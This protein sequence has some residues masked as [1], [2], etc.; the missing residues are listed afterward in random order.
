MH[1]DNATVTRDDLT[2][3]FSPN[4]GAVRQNC[5]FFASLLCSLLAAAGAVLA[6]QWLQHYERTGQIGSYREQ[7]LRRTAKAWGAET[8][9]LQQV[10]EMLPTLIL[11]SL[12]LFFVAISDYLWSVNWQVAAVVVAFSAAGT[13]LYVVMLVTAT[14]HDQSPFQ[15]APSALLH[16]SWRALL[17]ISQ[18]LYRPATVA[19]RLVIRLLARAFDNA[20]QYTWFDRAEDWLDEHSDLAAR[21]TAAGRGAMSTLSQQCLESLCARSLVYMVSISPD[22]DAVVVACNVSALSD[23][24]S[25]SLLVGSRVLPYLVLHC[26]AALRDLRREHTPRRE[27]RALTVSRA[28]MVLLMADP[29]ACAPL[30]D[31]LLRQHNMALEPPD[32]ITSHALR[33]ICHCMAGFSG[34]R[35]SGSSYQ[36]VRESMDKVLKS[37][38][39]LSPFL[40][41]LYLRYSLLCEICSGRQS[42]DPAALGLPASSVDV[43]RQLLAHNAFPLTGPFLNLVS[44]LLSRV[45][46]ASPM[47]SKRDLQD[48]I[49]LDCSAGAGYV[50]LTS[51]MRLRTTDDS[52]Q[53]SLRSDS[54]SPTKVL[55]AFARY[56]DSIHRAQAVAPPLTLLICHKLLVRRLRQLPRTSGDDHDVFGAVSSLSG[57]IRSVTSLINGCNSRNQEDGWNENTVEALRKCQTELLWI[58]QNAVYPR[59]SIGARLLPSLNTSSKLLRLAAEDRDLPGSLVNALKSR[60]AAQDPVTCGEIEWWT[61]LVLSLLLFGS[62]ADRDRSVQPEGPRE[63]LDPFVSI[64]LQPEPAERSSDEDAHR[65]AAAKVAVGALLLQPWLPR[66]SYSTGDPEDAAFSLPWTSPEC[67]S[68]V[69]FFILAAIQHA[70]TD[71]LLPLSDADNPDAPSECPDRIRV[72]VDHISTFRFVK[73]AFGSDSQAASRCGLHDACD[74]LI[75][76]LE[77]SGTLERTWT[78]GRPS[79]LRRHAD[80]AMRSYIR[81]APGRSEFGDVAVLPSDAVA[82]ASSAEL[83]RHNRIPQ[84]EVPLATSSGGA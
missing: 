24:G 37:P 74:K 83:G 49:Q 68:A 12:G 50:F 18:L 31:D 10:V 59:D 57:W 69:T 25:L 42:M 17:R 43:L 38:G 52:H 70:G 22:I 32:W 55:D 46:C 54:K 40:V 15:T 53:P 28:L 2:R 35:P 76:K 47:E 3:P 8:W 33:I 16:E 23:H 1:A 20:N 44:T 19:A 14:V 82:S 7:G 51:P 58:V 72:K 75:A 45:L 5:T 65:R 63:L 84:E 64:L 4:A 39:T 56:Y 34:W 21:E 80:N 71:I 9:R 61:L 78:S 6:K 79:D 66:D 26:D 77:G 62:T 11:M 27:E 48:V 30:I 60:P 73:Y 36:R 41:A 67:L 81:K 13:V 29:I